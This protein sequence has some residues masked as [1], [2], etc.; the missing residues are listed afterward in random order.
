MRAKFPRAAPQQI[1]QQAAQQPSSQA[2]PQAISQ[3]ACQ[4]PD[5]HHCKLCNASFSSIARLMRHTQENICNKPSCRHCDEV[6]LSKNQLHH[7]LR[8]DC[9]KR[10]H[11]Q[12]S[13]SPKYSPR[14]SPS[15]SPLPAY[16]AISPPPPRY[17]ATKSY[18]TIEDL[19]RMFGH[20]SAT[21]KSS[22]HQI[23]PST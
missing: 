9:K 21:T 22:N 20:G 8:K 14:S 18:L 3:S 17:E 19:F 11:R 5:Y 7:H 2:A 1:S 15:P 23:R 4:A 16:R 6:F 12:P 13:S 10:V